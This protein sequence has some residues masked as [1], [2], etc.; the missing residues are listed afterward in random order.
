MFIFSQTP[1]FQP[2]LHGYFQHLYS[3]GIA[4][5]L[6]SIVSYNDIAN[7]G[8]QFTLAYDEI[9]LDMIIQSQ[10]FNDKDVE[11]IYSTI[12]SCISE[13]IQRIITDAPMPL[14]PITLPLFLCFDE[15]DGKT[16]LYIEE[17]DYTPAQK[18]GGEKPGKL[19]PEQ[20]K[21]VFRQ[22]YLYRFQSN[23]FNLKWRI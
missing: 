1:G 3:Q 13:V 5:N 10:G 8:S 17:E 18:Y 6:N 11:A 15:Y 23:E 20:I 19:S 4:L 7:W 12:N 14:K 21:F 16:V 9:D 22:W 2:I